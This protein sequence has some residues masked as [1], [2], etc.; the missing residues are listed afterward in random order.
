[1]S[2]LATRGLSR[3]FGG[4]H[5]NNL[6]LEADEVRGPWSPVAGATPPYHKVIPSPVRKFY[7]VQL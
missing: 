7:R 2:L 5:A 6:S 1:M 3:E 4:L